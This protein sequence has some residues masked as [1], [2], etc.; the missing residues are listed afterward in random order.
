MS[1]LTQVAESAISDTIIPG[2]K[3]ARLAAKLK[4]GGKRRKKTDGTIDFMSILQAFYAAKH[5]LNLINKKK[6]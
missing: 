5:I 1:S 4:N 2:I 6:R 3:G